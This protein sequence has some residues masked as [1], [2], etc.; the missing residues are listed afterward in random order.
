[1]RALVIGGT[2][3]ISALL[4]RRLWADG[5]EVSV[6][7]RGRSG[8]E[9]P[10]EI[11]RLRAD[12][13]VPGELDRVLS[14][15]AF[16]VVY[17]QIAFEAAAAQQVYALLGRR[18][19]RYVL[20]SSGQVYAQPIG[21][22]IREDDALGP[23]DGY[24]AGKLAAERAAAECAR[25]T[26]VPAT[27]VRGNIT[28]GPR[29]AVPRRLAHLV[30]RVRHGQPIVVPGRLGIAGNLSYV[31]DTARLLVAAGT[32]SGPS[33]FR[34]YNAGGA[35]AHT[36][37]RLL[38]ALFSAVGRAV[39]VVELGMSAAEFEA[40]GRP[41]LEWH[42]NAFWNTVFDTSRA[43]V[44]LGWQPAIDLDEGLART[45]AWLERVR[46]D[47]LTCAPDPEWIAPLVAGR[48]VPSIVARRVSAAGVDPAFGDEL[49][50]QETRTAA[51]PAH[52]TSKNLDGLRVALLAELAAPALSARRPEE[53]VSSVVAAAAETGLL[54]A[55]I[56]SREVRAALDLLR[57]DGLVDDV[58]R[59]TSRGLVALWEAAGTVPEHPTESELQVRFRVLARWAYLK[60]LV[61]RGDRD[62]LLE[63][64]PG[65]AWTPEEGGIPAGTQGL[66]E[67]FEA[68]ASFHADATDAGEALRRWRGEVRRRSARLRAMRAALEA[69]A[70]ELTRAWA[71]GAETQA[72]VPVR[73]SS[74]AD[75]KVLL[76]RRPD[77]Q[78]RSEVE[79]A[80]AR[81]EA[82]AFEVD[83]LASLVAEWRD[84]ARPA[85]GPL[86][87]VAMSTASGPPRPG[88]LAPEFEAPSTSGTFRLSALRGRWIVLY[89]YPMDDTPGCTTQGCQFRDH[90][91]RYARANAVI[92]G[93]SVDG[94]ESHGGFR[95]RHGLPFELVS[96]AGRRVSRAYGVLDEAR[97]WARRVTFVIDPE[98]RVARVFEVDDLAGQSDRVLEALAATGAQ[99]A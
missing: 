61:A 66:F 7:A 12:R 45:V 72:L 80:L 39:P 98:G 10:S 94:L 32:R 41:L 47:L 65:Q 62:A 85:F 52:D 40:E 53:L 8:D 22:P 93:V 78:R 99:A 21:D 67:S 76:A 87:A 84:D 58:P 13:C 43:Q 95:T 25:Q 68:F 46:P 19:G 35:E 55:S 23:A 90:S 5:H 31:E 29:D 38:D 9:L 97:G 36:F 27:V 75:V 2:G 49:E 6:V 63:P 16:D 83:R 33:N 11:E 14:G 34:V 86:P 15:R 26:G 70:Q 69:E 74:R 4:V 57:E 59:V 3:F 20:L 81:L 50:R 73:V 56:A 92:V 17:D 71:A 24:G 79:P 42:H 44:E 96:D 88:E 48:E 1:M 18:M 37:E 28:Y 77:L 91:A 60:R 54:P 82:L 89:F 64:R 30:A 51:G